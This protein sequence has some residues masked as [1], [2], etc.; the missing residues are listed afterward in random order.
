MSSKAQSPLEKIF[1][2]LI[3]CCLRFPKHTTQNTYY[4]CINR[5]DINYVSI[6]HIDLTVIFLI[7]RGS[8][9]FLFLPLRRIYSLSS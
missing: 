4:Y 6:N 3:Q 5:Q 7:E 1:L 2:L 9:F 8:N